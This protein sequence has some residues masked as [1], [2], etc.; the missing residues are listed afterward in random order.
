MTTLRRA[1]GFTLIEILVVVVI[2]GVLVTLATLSVGNRALSDKLETESRRL[3]LLMR[4]AGE[5][6]EFGHQQ[7]GFR[8][9]AR[10]YEF[11]V[12]GEGA[13][14]KA[15]DEGPLRLRPLPEP[16]NMELRVEGRIVPPAQ[17]ALPKDGEAPPPPEPQIMFLSSGELTAF[18]LRMKAPGVE[19]DY[20]L[21][22]NELGT[23]EMERG[24]VK[25]KR[26]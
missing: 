21:S 18:E 16:L 19:G 13:Q 7:I 23:I 12:V 10:G 8:H 26:R 4:L 3:L 14:W 1:R 22:G 17:Q 9:T 15:I 24:D 25:D 5:E 2:I 20:V 6:A 11:L